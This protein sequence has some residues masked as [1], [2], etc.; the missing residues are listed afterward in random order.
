MQKLIIEGGAILDGDVEISGA[1][2]AVLPL[3]AATLL[4]ETP[5]TIRNV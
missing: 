3:L 4:A 2:N 1:K 5:M